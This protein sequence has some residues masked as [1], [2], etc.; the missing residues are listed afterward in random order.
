MSVVSFF[1][2]S[3]GEVVVLSRLWGEVVFFL[4]GFGY[5]AGTSFVYLSV[6]CHLWASGLMPIGGLSH[7][8][9]SVPGGVRD[10]TNA[11]IGSGWT[12]ACLL[13]GGRVWSALRHK[14]TGLLLQ[15][16]LQEVFAVFSKQ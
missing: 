8:C 5:Q 9:F 7:F 4:R 10:F 3:V 11:F 12:S 1:Y 6:T 14:G 16:D 13:V 15:K 2:G